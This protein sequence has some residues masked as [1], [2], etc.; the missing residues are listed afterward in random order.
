MCVYDEHLGAGRDIQYRAADS[1]SRNTTPFDDNFVNNHHHNASEGK[2]KKSLILYFL[3]KYNHTI[4][5]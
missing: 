2:N 1:R 3:N 5:K 4:N